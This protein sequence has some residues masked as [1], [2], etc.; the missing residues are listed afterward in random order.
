MLLHSF[1][2]S[3]YDFKMIWHAPP[4][5]NFLTAPCGPVARIKLLLSMLDAFYRLVRTH[6]NAWAHFLVKDN[7]WSQVAY[8][9]ACFFNLAILNFLTPSA[10]FDHAVGSLVDAGGG[11]YGGR[12]TPERLLLAGKTTS[13][14]RTWALIP[15]MSPSSRTSRRSI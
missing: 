8:R 5:D 2:Y 1:I 9:W 13:S 12:T 15:R 11:S 14:R 6:C 10:S 4:L 3:D 7:V